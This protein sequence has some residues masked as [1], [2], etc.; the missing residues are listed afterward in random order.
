MVGNAVMGGGYSARLNR[1]IR[2]ER[3]LSYGAGSSLSQRRDDGMVAAQVQ[4]RNDAAA[5]VVG[6]VL[7]EVTRLATEEATADELATRR[8]TLVG[9]YARSLETVDGLGGAVA[10]LANYG[11]PMT[12]MANFAGRVRAVTA[13][14]IQR[15]AAAELDPSEFSIIVVGD[16][17]MFIEALRAAHPN[18]EVIPI[19]ELDLNSAALR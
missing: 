2:I 12:D 18:V 1:E 16:A 11:L 15:V 7:T 4:T 6:L 3:G 5:E 13:S 17:S 8:A 10:S 19:D 14:D 9:G